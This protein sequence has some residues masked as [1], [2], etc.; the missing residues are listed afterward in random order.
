VNEVS[1]RQDVIPAR[2]A[3]PYGWSPEQTVAFVSGQVVADRYV[4]SGR[5]IPAVTAPVP[6]R[7]P[8]AFGTEDQI[9]QPWTPIR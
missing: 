5:P 8:L 2:D 1:G 9:P 7:L 4:S 3:C 6:Y